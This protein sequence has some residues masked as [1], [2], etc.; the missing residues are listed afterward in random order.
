[1]PLD[2]TRIAAQVGEMVGR[3]KAGGE[4]RQQHL[5]RALEV[6]K[7]KNINL[8]QRREN[9]EK[10]DNFYSGLNITN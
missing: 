5:H 3:L 7:D 9:N 4:E 8:D 10:Y 2:L 1:M 6:L